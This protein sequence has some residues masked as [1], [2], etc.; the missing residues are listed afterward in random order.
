LFSFGDE[1]I[2]IYKKARKLLKEENYDLIITSGEP[3]IL[4]KIMIDSPM[5]KQ[6]IPKIARMVIINVFI[7]FN[8]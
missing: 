2:M 6:N 4:F 3:F 7:Y 5:T 1:K 8:F